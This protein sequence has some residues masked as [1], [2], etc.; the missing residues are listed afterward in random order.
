LMNSFDE[1]RVIY[2]EGI[3][4]FSGIRYAAQRCWIELRPRGCAGC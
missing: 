3:V 4:L 1:S 2:F